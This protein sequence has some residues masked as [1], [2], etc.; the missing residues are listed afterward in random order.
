MGYRGLINRELLIWAAVSFTSKIPI[1]MTPLALVFLM[2]ATDGYAFGAT[3]AAC[4]VVGEVA[5]A[6]MQGM[7]LR[8]SRIRIEL[9]IGLAV[10]AAAFAGLS[11]SRHA[12]LPVL[13]VL[14]CIAGAGPAAS[15][16]GLRS[17]LTAMVP[18]RDVPR[19]LSAETMLADVIW[20]I[21]PAVVVALALRVDAAA[22][23]MLAALCAAMAAGLIF[24]LPE[25]SATP[26]P[27]GTGSPWRAV[28]SGWPIYLTSASAMSLL[29]IAELLLP[30]LL[31]FRRVPVGWAGPMLTVFAVT[32][33]VGAFCY[34]LR[35]WP[36]SV[37]THSLVL[38]VVTTGWVALLA[39]LPGIGIGIALAVAGFFQSAVIVARNLALR[40][41]L[42][43][44]YH[45]SAYS[46]MYAAS[47][48]GYGFTATV[49]AVIIDH[50]SPST[51]IL[52]AV[53]LTLLFTAISWL[54]ERSPRP[55]SEPA[56]ASTE[57]P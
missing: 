46:V 41:R 36:G 7:L 5:G 54:A 32:A 21:S 17:M 13:V 19:A 48:V 6:S 55:T 49:G 38:L 34:G 22:P 35:A 39:V 27:A 20:A 10:G 51:A 44:A 8:H 52:G 37:R 47:G 42:P 12:P 29:A 2:R 57:R 30:A 26:R 43:A 18:E 11:L 16:G 4:Y 45:S 50:A 14:A 31:E 3:L 33:A 25:P 24:L 56:Y 53:A 9:A 15:P 1:A 40:E 28:A 23:I